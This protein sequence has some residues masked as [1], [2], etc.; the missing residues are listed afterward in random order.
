MAVQNGMQFSYAIP[1]P[2]GLVRRDGLLAA[3]IELYPEQFYQ[4]KY[5]VMV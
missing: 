5:F 4:I 2:R 3:E 1:F